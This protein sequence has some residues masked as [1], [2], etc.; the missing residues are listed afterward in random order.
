MFD[1]HAKIIEVG[2]VDPVSNGLQD[3]PPTGVEKLPA[4]PHDLG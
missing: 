1:E 3:C 2:G 4:D